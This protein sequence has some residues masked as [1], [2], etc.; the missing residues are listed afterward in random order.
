MALEKIRCFACFIAALAL[1]L[2]TVLPD[3]GV[4]ASMPDMDSSEISVS[5]GM[6]CPDCPTNAMKAGSTSCTQ[7]SCIGLAVIAGSDP[8]PDSN[9]QTFF[10]SA[11]VWPDEVA[12]TPPTPPI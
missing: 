10:Q 11:T 3:I 2:V 1:L 12:L 7:G 8:L 4:N 6:M 5:N 9:H